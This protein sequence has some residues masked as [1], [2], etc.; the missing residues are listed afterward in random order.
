MSVPTSPVRR[1]L[2]IYVNHREF[3][4][5]AH[6]LPRRCSNPNLSTY[7]KSSKNRP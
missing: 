3:T 4:V 2:I 6:F 1:H 5:G 7:V